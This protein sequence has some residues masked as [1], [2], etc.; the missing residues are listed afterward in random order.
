MKRCVHRPRPADDAP[1]AAAGPTPPDSIAGQEMRVGRSPWLPLV[2]VVCR[3]GSSSPRVFRRRVR[4]HAALVATDAGVVSAVPGPVHGLRVRRAAGGLCLCRRDDR[5]VPGAAAVVSVGPEVFRVRLRDAATQARAFGP[6]LPAAAGRRPRGPDRLGGPSALSVAG[7]R[8]DA[9]GHRDHR[10]DGDGRSRQPGSRCGAE[11]G[12]GGSEAARGPGRARAHRPRPARPAR[13]HPVAGG[14][15]VGPR[16]ASARTRSGG[17]RNEINE[18][19]R[20]ARES[21]AQVRRAVSGIRAAGIAAELASAKLLLEPMAW[22]S[23][24]DWRM[25]SPAMRCRPAWKARWR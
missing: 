23:I 1:S 18:V 3:S 5:A 22:P 4:L 13:P 12:P 10:G 24:T 20:V 14:V 6:A 11:A 21:L 2:H 25:R 15:E 17:G 16:R 7:L 9:D 19:S 8:L